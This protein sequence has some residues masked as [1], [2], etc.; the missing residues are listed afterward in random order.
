M[1]VETPAPEHLLERLAARLDGATSAPLAVL[2]PGWPAALRQAA[3]IALTTAVDDGRLGEHDL[4]L[5]TSG[6]S[7]RPKGVVRPLASW[8]ASLQPL[9][10]ITGVTSAD[11]VW[12]PLPLTSGLSLYGGFHAR[13]L[14]AEVVV[15]PLRDAVPAR[16]TVA[17]VVPT[18][19]AR[20]CELSTAGRSTLRTVVV[21]GAGLAD[22]L[23][24]RARAVGLD[25]VEY[26]GAAELS[27]VGWRREAGPMRDF[28]GATVRLT[29]D[30][31]WVRSP[32][33][34]T[35][36]LDPGQPGPLRRDG[37]W[38]SVGDLGRAVPGGW[39]VLGRGDA[40]VSTGGHTVVAEELEAALAVLPG[41]EDVAVLGLPHASLGQVVAAVVVVA[42]GTRRADLD[43][44]ARE[45][46][47]WARPRRWL[48]AD[49]LPRT[50]AGKIARGRLADLAE[51]LPRLP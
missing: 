25:V 42:P 38:A 8:R 15:A 45:L 5:F 7:G 2:D 18:Q 48:E 12:L 40:A 50:P 29:D 39:E 31:V 14:G 13:S 51:A 47:A 36:Y 49:A 17:H 41:V 1:V 23:R 46:P 28:P 32:Y 34:C 22:S 33:V 6:S 10:G 9:S 21:A 37:E 19:L 44:R 3:Q 11:V 24:E 43:Q 35:G 26:Y 30:E 4:V 16:A 20:L 27:F